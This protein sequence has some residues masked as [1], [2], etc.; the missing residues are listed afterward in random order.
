MRRHL[1]EQ[2]EGGQDEV[3]T[4]NDAEVLRDT[5]VVYGSVLA[6]TFLLFC[7]VRVKFPRPYSIR[8]WV[9]KFKTSLAD[10]HYGY[11]S[12]MW[13][14]RSVSE[15][16]VLDECGMDSLCQLR[17]LWMGYKISIL[18]AFLSIFLMP[19]Y[20]TAEDSEETDYITDA[21]VSITISHV[22]AGSNRLIGTA[23]AAYVLFF[24]VM[25]LILK[26][27][28]WFIEMRHKYL[29]KPKAC[30]YAVYVRN[31]PHEYSSNAGLER[32]FEQ[33]FSADSVLEARLRVKTPKLQAA[34][35][36]RDNVLA[37]L[38]HALAY[39]EV[40]QKPPMHREK[41]S[42]RK[43]V[44][45]PFYVNQLKDA[46]KEVKFRLE[47]IESKTM[48]NLYA[49]QKSEAYLDRS[50]FTGSPGSVVRTKQLLRGSMSPVEDPSEESN[51]GTASDVQTDS[52]SE[53]GATPNEDKKESSNLVSK[54][55]KKLTS[56]VGVVASTAATMIKGLEEG[57]FYSAGF[58][59]FT[60][61]G[62]KH[63]AL[64]MVHHERPFNIEVMEAPGPEDIF[65]ANV[66]RQH[67]DLQLGKLFSLAATTALCLLWTIPMTFL[68]SLNSVEALRAEV[69]FID[70][71]L[72]KAPWLGP[73]FEQIAPLL[74]KIFNALLPIFLELFCLFEG[75]VSSSIVEASL[76]TKLSAFMII[77]T[78]FVSAISGGLL[79]ELANIID[80]P[81]SVIDL[82]ANS[83]PGQ[84]TYFIQIVFV[85]VVA[86]L[87][88]ELLRIIPLI[89]AL[90]RSFLP[91]KLTKKERQTTVLG[92][93]PLADPLEF[94]QADTLS[95]VVLSFVVM[96]VYAV[97]ASLTAFVVGFCFLY[98]MIAY[99]YQ[100][101][102]IYP[103]LPDSGGQIWKNFI[104][105]LTVCLLIAQFT[106]LGLLG[107]KKATIAA[108]LMI[109]LIVVQFLFNAYIGQEHFRVAENLPSRECLKVDQQNGPDFDLSF[110]KGAYVQE[111]LTAEEAYPEEL[112][113]SR[114]AEL[115][116]RDEEQM[117]GD[118][119]SPIVDDKP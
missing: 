27:F 37:K 88:M 86:S 64:Q 38:E 109:P 74:V 111:E 93:R 18:C 79:Q 119:D 77:Q 92:M 70:D 33:C 41:F 89:K 19:L 112:S 40:K 118:A 25:Y 24:Y 44:S 85:G 94:E 117:S 102:Y 57:D 99:K 52:R 13:H 48:M 2:T 62:T 50:V 115:G 110:V 105:I 113:P 35:T 5:F 45:I 51:N 22:P 53:D 100:Y 39:E 76:F 95:Q 104:R 29:K 17:L 16:E 31:I 3:V 7:Y 34:V 32:F 73:V 75:P 54:S 67:K 90:I 23:L 98:T 106:I 97:I 30:N 49:G 103:T 114:M 9:E 14:L 46:N 8:R 21:I 84:S 42:R 12:W 28:D 107:L 65:W 15:D 69:K 58:V 20:A 101:I 78:F 10:E 6:V 63:A 66:G 91:P 61:L 81:T 43:I 83:L 60:D 68:A 108:P 72:E 55:L 59:S 96:L 4:P 82:L 116:L 26:E 56:N 87:G 80:D 11:F 71:L 1:E 36:D 47:E